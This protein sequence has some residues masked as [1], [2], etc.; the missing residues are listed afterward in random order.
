MN[1]S[2]KAMLVVA[3]LLGL[4]QVPA[5]AQRAPFASPLPGSGPTPMRPYGQSGGCS[6][7][8]AQFHRC[9]MAKMKEFNPPRT[10]DGKPDFRGFWNRIVVRNMENIEEHPETMDG[11]GGKSSVID[12]A[13][14]KIPYQPWA[15]ARREQQFATYLNPSQVCIPQGSPKQAY[16]PGVMRVLQT[17]DTVFMLNDFAHTYRTIPTDGRPH[18]GSGIAL[19]EGDSRGR[20]EGNTLVV[21]VTNQKDRVWL[22]AVGN[23][24][25]DAVHV[26][27]RFTLIDKDVIHIEATIDDPKVY[28]RPWTMVIGWRR[29]TDKPLEI[30]E[31]ACWEGVQGS[32]DFAKESH[33]LYPGALPK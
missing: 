18:L 29:N 23:F 13:D 1:S 33:K 16:G 2:S 7:E 27:E 11:S 15:A 32:L 3:L 6:E 26:V 9:A 21:D 10:P 12:P 30:W 20:W 25:S 19:Y 17:P 22:D 31:G 5:A 24:F 14:G 4:Q 28:T 8:P